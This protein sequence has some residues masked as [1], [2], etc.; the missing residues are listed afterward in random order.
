MRLLA[1][2]LAAVALHA[3]AAPFTVSLGNDRV[4]LDSIPGMSDALPLG[5]PRIQEL[6]ESVTSASNR[7]LLFA[8]TDADI[9]RFGLGERTDLKRYMLA[10]TPNHLER[11]RVTPQQFKVLIDDAQR[12]SGKPPEIADYMKHL[13]ERPR[14]QPTALAQLRQTGEVYSVLLGTR[15]P[16]MGGW[17]SKAQYLVSTN[18]FLLVRNKALS[19]SVYSSYDGPQDLEWI[20][21]VTE[22]WIDTLQ[23]L[24]NR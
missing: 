8:L 18:T 15:L 23:K 10:V 19:L 2:L 22:R 24:N 12:D 11:E 1:A 6:A 13:D 20:R 7:I 14:G 4:V 17:M 3:G 16:D 9:R 5:S 21:F